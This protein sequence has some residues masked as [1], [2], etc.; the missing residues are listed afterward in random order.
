MIAVAGEYAAPF[1]RTLIYAVVAALMQA[2]GW[3]VTLPLFSLVLEAGPLPV[4]DIVKWLIVLLL[5]MVA[6]GL[7]RW[8]EIA[9]VYDYWHRV[10]EAMRM[11]LAQRLRIIPLEQLARRKSGD[12]AAILG[13]NVTFAATAISSL[14]TLAVQLLVVPGVLLLMIFFLDWRLGALLLAG[15]LFALPLMLRVRLAAN[16]DFK[17]IDEA[18]AA[19]S[20]AIIEYVQG[21]AMLRASGRSGSRA[22]CLRDVFARQHQAQHQSGSTT[23]RIALSQLIIQLTLV[24]TVA[25]G[26]WLCASQQLPLPSLLCLLVLIAQMAEPLSLGLS[27]VRLFELADAALQRVNTL[28]SQAEMMTEVPQQQPANFSFQLQNLSF[29]YQGQKKPVIEGLTLTIPEK[30]LTALVGPSGGGKLR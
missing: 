16:H 20:A 30:S 1:Q 5:L 17:T 9:F 19:T 4:N 21:Q 11:R 24:A 28:L 6:E 25:L 10:T 15:G 2:A 12:L 14:A 27:M 22:P 18:D 26:I 8:H 7:V 23:R 29:C 3:M 13:N